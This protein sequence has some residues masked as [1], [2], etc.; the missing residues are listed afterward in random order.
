MDSPGLGND[1]LIEFRIKLLKVEEYA[2]ARAGDLVEVL[3]ALQT[4][5]TSCRHNNQSRNATFM[6]MPSMKF[7]DQI[8]LN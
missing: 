8:R 1:E 2:A 3:D 6:T 7:T 5:D 4:L